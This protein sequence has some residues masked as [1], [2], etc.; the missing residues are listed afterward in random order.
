M[1]KLS[2]GALRAAMAM[3]VIAST[4]FFLGGCAPGLDPL[5]AIVSGAGIAMPAGELVDRPTSDAATDTI[6]V[7]RTDVKQLCGRVSPIA[8]HLGYRIDH[9]DAHGVTLIRQNKNYAATLIGKEWSES[10]TINVVGGDVLQL[11]ARCVGN[12]GHADPGTAQKLIDE[13]KPHLI[14]A[15]AAR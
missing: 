8:R 14:A 7:P 9:V 5:T 2:F 12:G 3:L 1:K 6:H 4:V 11:M 15:Y 13:L 10:V